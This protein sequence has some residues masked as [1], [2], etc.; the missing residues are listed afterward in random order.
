V[1]AEITGS[2]VEGLDNDR[3]MVLPNSEA[4]APFFFVQES[5]IRMY[6]MITEQISMASGTA[7]KSISQKQRPLEACFC[8]LHVM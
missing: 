2:H 6:F 7:I 8:I 1:S 4:A 5:R 3:L